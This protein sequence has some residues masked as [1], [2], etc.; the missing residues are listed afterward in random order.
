MAVSAGLLY[1][2][3]R[4]TLA[5]EMII[6]MDL[7][8]TRE[9]FAASAAHHPYS[10]AVYDADRRF[11]YL[12]PH[13][14]KFLRKT[15]DEV[16]GRRDEEV[17][18]LEMVNA[19]L[20]ALNRAME[21]RQPQSVVAELMLASNHVCLAYTFTPLL[22]ADG[23]V[24]EVLAVT[25]DMTSVVQN[26]R[27][28]RRL[29]RTLGAISAANSVLVRATDEA[30]LL[31]DFC[32]ELAAQTGHRLVWV[33]FVEGTEGH[34]RAAEEAG[35][36]A[37]L[38]AEIRPGNLLPPADYCVSTKA[39]QQRQPVICRD[40]QTEAL[41]EP[42]RVLAQEAGLRSG[43]ALPLRDD[44]HM[45]GALCLY[46]AEANQFD[47]QEVKMLA[48]LAED[49]TFGLVAL[50]H[51]Q[52][53]AQTLS[54]LRESE[55][56]LRTLKMV[57]DVSPS[58]AYVARTEPGW[59]VEFVSD[60][61]ARFGYQPSEF[62]SGQI[63]VASIAHPDDLPRIMAECEQAVAEGRPQFTQEYRVFDAR[64]QT[65]WVQDHCIIVRNTAG[66]ATHFQGI[67]TDITERKQAEAAHRELERLVQG[68]LDAMTDNICVLEA[69][70]AI[71]YVNASWRRFAA[72]RPP[73]PEHAAVGSNYFTACEHA[74][75]TPMGAEAAQFIAGTRAV[76]C[77]ELPEFQMEYSCDSPKE[78]QCFVARVT[79]FPAGGRPR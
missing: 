48:E 59:P 8:E 32:A 2:L 24:R 64:G 18:P 15:P 78:H 10:F 60:N 14:L 66:L 3:L 42:C 39:V 58:V 34:L 68:T 72:A 21:T 45:L 38:L 55:E 33:G 50:R 79:P 11:R 35:P 30:S 47:E 74:H 71:A 27:R 51:K 49:L 26:E 5:R 46:A 56:R 19:Y 61:V 12:N 43:V 41:F 40:Y 63:K 4:R 57:I 44:G 77:G 28:V 52:A 69:D 53:L 31:R 73:A 9:R 6:R 67:L 22:N 20:P 7:E 37:G 62:T 13:G 65:R 70:G 36:A 16:L 17:F 54:R 1:L 23:S 76:L 75:G 29:N 25:N